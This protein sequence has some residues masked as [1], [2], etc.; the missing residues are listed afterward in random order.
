MADIHT[1]VEGDVGAG[2]REVGKAGYPRG[3][4]S[5]EVGNEFCNIAQYFAI[6]KAHRR[7]NH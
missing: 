2:T 5:R 4:E 3:W 7:G 6:E 1:Q